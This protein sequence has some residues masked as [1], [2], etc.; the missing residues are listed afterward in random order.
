MNPVDFGVRAKTVPNFPL[1]F[2]GLLD[3]G[4]AFLSN[5]SSYFSLLI[6]LSNPHISITILISLG[7]GYFSCHKKQTLKQYGLIPLKF[8][9]CLC[10]HPV[11]PV[12]FPFLVIQVPR[13]P[14][15]DSAQP[16]GLRLL[17]ISQQRMREKKSKDIMGGTSYPTF[18]RALA[19]SDS[20]LFCL[21]SIGNNYSYSRL[22]IRNVG[23]S[24]LGNVVSG[25]AVT[26]SATQTSPTLHYTFSILSLLSWLS[27]SVPSLVFFYHPLRHHFPQETYP[28]RLDFGGATL[29]AYRRLNLCQGVNLS[30]S[31]D[32]TRSLTH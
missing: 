6:P 29:M 10:Y 17:C 28:D 25:R 12:A 9:S 13:C 7:L 2:S 1:H 27:L 19:Q 5:F 4:Q 30:R 21:D 23:G 3:L 8:I 16:Q 18:L 24:M 22:A 11:S 14:S 32:T 20:C 31:N 15:C 26:I